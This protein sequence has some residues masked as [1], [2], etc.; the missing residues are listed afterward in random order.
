MS[1][2]RFQRAFAQ[3]L[4]DAH[5]RESVFSSEQVPAIA[6]GVSPEE[7]QRLRAFDRERLEIFAELLI[8]NRLGKAAEGLPWTTQLLGG[9]IW[10]IAQ[11]FNQASPPKLSKKYHEAMA[12]GSFLGKRFRRQPPSIPFIDDVRIYEMTSLKM[13]F[14]FDGRY[15]PPV[16]DSKSP[17]VEEASYPQGSSRIVPHLVT[18]NSILS[19][20]YDVEWIGEEINQGRIPVAV[21]EKPMHILFHVEPS[22]VLAQDEINLPAL[23][24]LKA[25]D[26]QASLAE[27]ISRLAEEF[28]CNTPQHLD[29]F[30]LKCAELCKSLV[31]KK[32]IT[33]STRPLETSGALTST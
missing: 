14:G 33:L 15:E 28:D 27:V 25:C 20:N 31:I 1:E 11:E 2:Y 23:C 6:K 4:T 21:E 8:V 16:T 18:H 30:R 17:L 10:Q 7:E 32:V 12:F 29:K 3:L 26:G 22:G 24:F 13:R 9:E 19:L 5:M